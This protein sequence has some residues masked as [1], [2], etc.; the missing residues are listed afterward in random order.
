MKSKKVLGI[1]V[2]ST[3]IVSQ[4]SFSD[5]NIDRLLKEAKKL[6]A[7]QIVEVKDVEEVE[8]KTPT[9]KAPKDK[10]EA[11]KKAKVEKKTTKNMTES[12]KM[13]VE[14]QRMDCQ[15]FLGQFL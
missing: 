5:A 9:V 15:H 10:K 1:A 14:V 11:V 8:V 2:L 6:Q 4:L 13:D 3:L 12:Q 7:A